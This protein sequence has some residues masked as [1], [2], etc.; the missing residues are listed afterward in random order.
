MNRHDDFSPEHKAK[1]QSH[2]DSLLNSDIDDAEKN[3][4]KR[5]ASILTNTYNNE[6]PISSH[7]IHRILN[8]L[9]NGDLERDYPDVIENLTKQ[10]NFN[11]E[12]VEKILNKNNNNFSK[13]DLHLLNTHKD[14]ISDEHLNKMMHSYYPYTDTE[15]LG[16]KAKEELDRRR[17]KPSV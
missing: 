9:H 14:K 16:N 1:I 10:K 2:L 13:V 11:K 5:A 3:N 7:G 12:H 17:G 4:D 8:I 15:Y 6:T